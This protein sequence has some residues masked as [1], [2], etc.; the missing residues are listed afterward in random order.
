MTTPLPAIDYFRQLTTVEA[1]KFLSVTPRTLELMRQH[2]TGPLYVR[3]TP[4]CIRY[5][6][7]DIIDFQEKNIR[8]NTLEA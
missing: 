6:M 4:K 2:G 1:A 7:K 5:R 8:Q 3:V